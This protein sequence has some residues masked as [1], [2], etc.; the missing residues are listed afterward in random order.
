MWQAIHPVHRS[1][2]VRFVTAGDHLLVE[3]LVFF[4]PF[5]FFSA[6]RCGG[7]N[8]PKIRTKTIQKTQRGSKEQNRLRPAEM[9]RI[10][11]SLQ[12][13][14]MAHEALLVESGN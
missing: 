9:T 7:Q 13:F 3:A 14:G 11:I 10:G 5:S 12:V 1:R 6:V 2:E 4:I 8:G